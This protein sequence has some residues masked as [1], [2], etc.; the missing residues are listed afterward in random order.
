MNSLTSKRSS[1][2]AFPWF[3]CSRKVAT[4]VNR[5][6]SKLPHLP[7]FAPSALNQLCTQDT[8]GKSSNFLPAFT[9][10]R[11]ASH[12]NIISDFKRNF[13]E[14]QVPKS[15]F[16]S[17][18]P[19]LPYMFPIAGQCTFICQ[20]HQPN[21]YVNETGLLPRMGKLKWLQELYITSL[22][23]RP[24][25]NRFFEGLVPRL[26]HNYVYMYWSGP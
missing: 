11:W 4:C 7:I 2:L 19:C 10:D 23:A 15:N 1:I 8:K 22:E 3:P 21:L 14:Q 9:V 18:L 26:I 17:K 12:T 5:K 16:H 13:L 24:S 25:K 6:C 20:C